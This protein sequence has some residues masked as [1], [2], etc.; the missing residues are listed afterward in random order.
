M[1]LI[2]WITCMVSC[3]WS[4][5]SMVSHD[6]VSAADFYL[7][8]YRHTVSHWP[9]L[10]HRHN[11]LPKHM[12]WPRHLDCFVTITSPMLSTSSSA[13]LANINGNNLIRVVKF[14]AQFKWHNTITTELHF[15]NNDSIVNSDT[16]TQH[17]TQTVY[18]T[19]TQ[20]RTF[21]LA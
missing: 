16:E 1:M 11:L 12:L 19:I 13:S 5:Y 4:L 3:G 10:Y 6:R 20:T 21:L 14:T 9:G 17:V 15:A 2:W 7:L 18:Q 8:S